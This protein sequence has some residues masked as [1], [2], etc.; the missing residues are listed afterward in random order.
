WLMPSPLALLARLRRR[1]G[2]G[3]RVA[4]ADDAGVVVNADEGGD[5][6]AL[7]I[8]LIWTAWGFLASLGANF[9]VNRWL[10]HYVL[11]FRSIRIPSRWAMICYAGLAVLAGIGA[12]KLASR[13]SHAWPRARGAALVVF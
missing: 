12:S 9:F 2:R 3:A 13:A 6:D 5:R 11:P 4:A 7:G 1:W 8:A 10:H